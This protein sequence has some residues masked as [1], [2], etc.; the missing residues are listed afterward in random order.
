MKTGGHAT[1]YQAPLQDMELCLGIICVYETTE[2]STEKYYPTRV[3][4][5][6]VKTIDN[7]SAI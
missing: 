7:W 3:C 6:S 4:E 1:R 2:T 5:R